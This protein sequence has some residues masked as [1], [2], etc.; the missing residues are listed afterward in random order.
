[1]T[2]CLAKEW[3]VFRGILP[4]YVIF[5]T[6]LLFTFAVKKPYENP[7][8]EITPSPNAT[9]ALATR[10]SIL[11]LS[12]MVAVHSRVFGHFMKTPLMFENSSDFSDPIAITKFVAVSFARK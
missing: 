7:E 6:P 10:E 2:R 9:R 12:L 5:A 11:L 8:E 4:L 1:M 3:D